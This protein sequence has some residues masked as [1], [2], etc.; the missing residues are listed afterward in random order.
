MVLAV[1]NALGVVDACMPGEQVGGDAADSRQWSDASAEQLHRHQGSSNGRVRRPREYCNKADGGHERERHMQQRRQDVAHGR[2]DVKQ[3][4][5]LAALEARPQRG[6]REHQLAQEVPWQHG[7]LEGASDVRNT[8]ADVAVG[9]ERPNRRG[10]D[11]AAEERPQWRVCDR[12][13]A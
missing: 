4:C 12:S 13:R 7:L 11:E 5:H 9:V 2:T 8:Q 10:D 1:A 3:R 6:D